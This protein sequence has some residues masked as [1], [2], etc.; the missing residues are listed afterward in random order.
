MVSYS[1]IYLGRH[2]LG[3]V[4]VGAIVGTLVAMLAWWAHK[5]WPL[6]KK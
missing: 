4:L 5:K 2:Y 6:K 1:R 3:D